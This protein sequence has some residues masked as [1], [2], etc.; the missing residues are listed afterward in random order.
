M[1]TPRTMAGAAAVGEA[2]VAEGVVAEAVAAEEVLPSQ[3]DRPQV[4]PEEGITDSLD[5]PPTYSL[6]IA[7]RQKSSSRNG[8]STTT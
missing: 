3:E 5:N 7:R 1:K 2:A 8:N 4:T 6:G